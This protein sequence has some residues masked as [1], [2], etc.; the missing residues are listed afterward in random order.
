MRCE[1]TVDAVFDAGR[2]LRRAADTV[3]EIGDLAASSL[4]VLD[5]AATD[6]FYAHQEERRGFYLGSAGDHLARLRDKSGLMK[7]LG[8]DLTRHL[9]EAGSA[10]ERAGDELAHGTVGAER[11]VDV[12]ALRAQIEVLSEVVM[13]ARPIA[14]QITRHA[15]HAAE[16]AAATDALMLLDERVHHADQEV[17]RADEGVSMMRSVLERAQSRART[18]AA[19]AGS[20]SYVSTQSW[21]SGPPQQ[22]Y[23]PNRPADPGIAI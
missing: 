5:D 16:S 14:D 2:A 23:Q 15:Q 8:E 22:P 3:D 18:S 19:L 11:D 1:L 13:L 17:T 21:S 20:L 4:R 9:T 7:D 10:I 6:T 12:R